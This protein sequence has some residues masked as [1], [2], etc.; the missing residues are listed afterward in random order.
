MRT[1]IL[2]LLTI[3][4]ANFGICQQNSTFR[5]QQQSKVERIFAAETQ[6]VELKNSFLLIR[7]KTGKNTIDAMLKAGQSEMAEK[8]QKQ[9]DEEN[10]RI[11]KSF[12]TEFDF[13]PVYFFY[14][15]DSKFV[16]EKQ[17]E[18]VKFLNDSLQPDNTIKLNSEKFFIAEWG[19]VKGDTASY[20]S[21]TSY[22][23]DGNFSQGP[24]YVYYGGGS[25]DAKGLI[26]KD[27][28][29]HQ[30][31]SPFPFFIKN[32]FFRKKEKTEIY[33][34]RELNRKLWDYLAAVKR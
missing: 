34:V 15:D 19:N 9:I 23:P 11:I 8:R 4:I 28:R 31:R 20:Y 18:K 25:T 26:V 30:L 32:P 22:E 5:G 24:V 17:F 33:V 10:I 29:F 14:S 21:H 1:S 13:C 16:A 2:F 27:C 3:L 7:L 6:I 12:R